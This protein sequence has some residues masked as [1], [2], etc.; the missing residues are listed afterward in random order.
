MN[1]TLKHFRKNDPVLYGYAFRVGNLEP[2]TKE[3][4]QRYFYRLCREIIGQQLHSKAAHSIFGRF[5]KLFPHST[6]SPKKILVLSHQT[7]RR[8][9]MSHAKARYIRNLAEQVTNRG[10]QIQQLD[11]MT[12][13]EAI[14]ELTK[15]KGV[16]RWTAEMFLIFA[17]GR[18]DVFSYGD[19][20]LKKGM[21]KIYKL[22]EEPSPKRVEQIIQKWSPYKTYAT[23]IL[24]ASLKL[25]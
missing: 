25:E 20:A 14:A 9:G 23:R 17:L 3:K 24:W 1:S 22:R 4:P 13:E 19:L 10:I 2:I 15:V 16:G 8:T 12:D 7:L 6:V 18:N 21:Q 5:Q 11:A